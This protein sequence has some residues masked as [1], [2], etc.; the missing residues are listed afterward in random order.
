[1]AFGDRREELEGP[2]PQLPVR[3]R[4]ARPG[5]LLQVELV[6]EMAELVRHHDLL[7]AVRELVN[8]GVR[9]EDRRSA[10]GQVQVGVD[11][12]RLVTDPHLVDRQAP[13][14]ERR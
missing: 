14:P 1:M 3:L 7:F 11:A 13:P 4:D 10:S 12:A 6:V 2:F 9:D 8:Q 5:P